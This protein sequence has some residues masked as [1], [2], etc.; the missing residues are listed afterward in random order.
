VQFLATCLWLRGVG[1]S[2]WLNDAAAFGAHGAAAS[3]SLA[4]SSEMDL[5][6]GAF[7]NFGI[8]F[9]VGDI[10]AETA[11]HDG[12]GRASKVLMCLAASAA[13]FGDQLQA[14]SRVMVNGSSG[15]MEA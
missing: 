2:L 10:G 12:D 6:V 7:G 15:L 9:A 4:W 3:I 11:V 5:R 1:R 8:L 13:F 14:R